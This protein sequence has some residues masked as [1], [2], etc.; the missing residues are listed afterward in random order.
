[1]ELHPAQRRV[2]CELCRKSKAK[3]ERIQPDDLKCVR[4]LLA[5]V[6][7][8]SGRQKKVGR[9][10]R[11][12]LASSSVDGNSPLARRRQQTA[13]P[14]SRPRP[15]LANEQHGYA[16]LLA[17]DYTKLSGTQTPKTHIHSSAEAAQPWGGNQPVLSMTNSAT[18][19]L[20]WLGRAKAMDDSWCQ[21]TIPGVARGYTNEDLD[22]LPGT[23]IID[24]T[25]PTSTGTRNIPAGESV[26]QQSGFASQ[27][28]FQGSPLSNELG[29]RMNVDSSSNYHLS[30]KNANLPFGIGRPPA[31]YVHANSFSSDH[32]DASPG[33]V[34]PDGSRAMVRL[35]TMLHGLRLRS[36]MIRSNRSRMHLGLL[37]HRQGPL[38]FGGYSPCEYVMVAAQELVQIVA[39]LVDNPGTIYTPGDAISAFLI[40][41]VADIY[42][43]LLSFLELFLENLTDG[44]ERI[45]VRP[46]VP[47]PGLMY[48]NSIVTGPC[49]QGTLFT[50][51]VF[52]L[53]GKLEDVLGLDSTSEGGLLSPH[54]VDLLFN[55]LDRS[56]DLLRTKGIMRP[57][58][59]RKLY[60]RISH[61]LERLSM[62]E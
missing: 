9:P 2:S 61:L 46:V 13:I 15:R 57:A 22:F 42:S 7:C 29:S 48:N 40:S 58:D 6:L 23:L 37:I 34:D 28:T 41:T 54:Q 36:T 1:M 16:S 11:T 62:N 56:D 35:I 25:L 53:L 3:C 21:R 38:F 43:R 31:Y 27:A 12:E 52:Y 5:N 44:V 17:R 55:K 33:D 59:M 60:A 18:P 30:K 19:T 49:T 14:R 20:E 8:E 10:K 51:T 4:C 24:P 47:L 39:I 45:G 26:S 50:S 32:R